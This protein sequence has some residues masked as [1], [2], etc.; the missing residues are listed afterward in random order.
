MNVYIQQMFQFVCVFFIMLYSIDSV[1]LVWELV[2]EI[3]LGI[4]TAD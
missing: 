4:F 3:A 1:S 2:I